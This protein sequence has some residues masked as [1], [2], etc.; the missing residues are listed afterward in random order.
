MDRSTLCSNQATS[1][2]Q[3]GNLIPGLGLTLSPE[4][5]GIAQDSTNQSGQLRISLA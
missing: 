3:R 2:M 1:P 4:T 5:R